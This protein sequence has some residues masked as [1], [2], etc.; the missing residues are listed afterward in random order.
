MKLQFEDIP[1]GLGALGKVPALGWFQIVAYCGFCEL[2]QDQSK[3]T[4]GSR[5]EFGFTVLTSSDPEQKKKKLNSELANGRLAMM[6]II[7]MFYQDGLTGSAWGD[8]SLYTD[9]PLRSGIKSPGWN[10]LPDFDVPPN[11]FEGN[12]GDQPPL[13]FWDP[14]GYTADGDFNKFQ[15]RREVEIKHGRVSMLAC[16]S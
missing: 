11:G 14:L 10:P 9:S 2:S 16:I 1:N 3:G 6:A 4:P 8:W 7:G 15:R 5:G 12:V 13:G